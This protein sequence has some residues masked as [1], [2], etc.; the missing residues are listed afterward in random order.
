MKQALTMEQILDNEDRREARVKL[1]DKPKTEE[2]KY[3]RLCIVAHQT[4]EVLKD[5]ATVTCGSC[6]KKWLIIHCCK[7]FYC[8]IFFCP[9]CSR[10]HFREE[11][12][13]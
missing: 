11:A 5:K 4:R 12:Q 3:E 1:H 10:I 6:S 9:I 7:C 13:A 2:E 8:G